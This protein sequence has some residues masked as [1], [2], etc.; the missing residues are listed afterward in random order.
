MIEY[1]ILSAIVAA[2]L[3]YFD[4]AAV[5]ALAEEFDRR[6]VK[7]GHTLRPWEALGLRYVLFLTLWPAVVF[8]RLYG[9][10]Y[11]SKKKENHQAD[12]QDG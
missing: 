1:L 5:I 3:T 11:G 2:V 8:A 10:I 9:A 6:H 12:D 7:Q 4:V